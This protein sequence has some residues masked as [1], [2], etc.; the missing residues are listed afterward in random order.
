VTINQAQFTGKTPSEVNSLLSQYGL[1]GKLVP[2]AGTPPTPADAGTAFSAAPVGNVNRGDTVTVQFYGEFPQPPAPAALTPSSTSAA[3]GSTVSIGI[4]SYTS[5][6]NA[7]TLTG[8]TFTSSSGSSFQP[9]NVVP[10]STTTLQFKL[11]STPGDNTISYVALCSGATSA[12][13]PTL[14]ITGD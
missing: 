2:D 7:S 13:S 9:A 14:T 8:F 11:S 1:S 10:A 5:C 3:A 12:A 6:P 4:P